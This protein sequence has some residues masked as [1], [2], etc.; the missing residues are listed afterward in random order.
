MGTKSFKNRLQQWWHSSFL[1]CDYSRLWR[2]FM[3]YGASGVKYLLPWRFYLDYVEIPITTRC[4]LRCPDCANLM[5]LYNKP[6]DVDSD[7]VIHSIRKLSEC[8]DACGQ[9]RILGGEPFLHPDLK[10][11]VAELPSHKCKKI[12]IPTNATIVPQ[13]PELYEILRQKKVVIV[14]GNYPSAAKT[15]QELITRLELEGIQYEIPKP[16]TWINYGEPIDHNH[17]L[18]ERTKQFACC[19]LRSKSLLNGVMYYCPRQGHGCDL[20]IIDKIEGEFVDV[21]NNTTAQNRKQLRR[22]MWR[23]KPVEACKYCLR[24]TNEAVSIS[25]GK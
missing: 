3:Y 23:H 15:Q 7:T 1:F 10:R 22:L 14:M 20:G 16:G 9:M 5:P 19:N 21:V 8:F 24:G 11:F 13:D 17:T 25:R 4:N 2:L 6:Y 12:S 18:R